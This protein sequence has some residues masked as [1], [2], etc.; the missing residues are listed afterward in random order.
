MT[1]ANTIASTAAGVPRARRKALT[2]RSLSTFGKYVIVYGLGL[3]FV[4]FS[5]LPLLW[6]VSTALKL[7]EDVYAFP[8]R[9]IPQTF[10]FENFV[11]VFNNQNLIHAFFNTLIIAIST[12]IVALIV[13][14][15]GGYGFA[16]FRFPGRNTLLWSV[17]FIKLFPRVVVIVPFF[18][19]LRNLQLINTYQGLILVYLMV[20]F[21][22]AIWLLKGFFDKIPKEIEE[23][24]IVDGCSLPQLLWYVVLP[25]ARPA[26]VAVAMY[27]F[28][29]SWNEFLFALVFTNGLERRPLAVA[30]AFFIDE[31]GIRWGELM[32][33]SI[34]MSLPAI[35]VFTLA[36]RMLVRGLSDGA[37]K[38]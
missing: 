5:I 23:A 24:A 35:L 26:I 19:T 20:T 30:L 28:I 34:V 15:L 32:A 8:P 13:G 7:P 33:A 9:W 2:R 6:G 25:M 17:L 29:L 12:T 14:V 3:F 16:R 1:I 22:V 18:V 27:S 36:Q 21:P 38:G 10:T 31:N 4:L 11:A 37:V